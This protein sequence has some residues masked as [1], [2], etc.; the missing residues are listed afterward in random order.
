MGNEPGKSS[1]NKNNHTLRQE[2]SGLDLAKCESCLPKGQA[3][4]QLFFL[5]LLTC[6]L[7]TTSTLH[8]IM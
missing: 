1:S 8:H 6:K 7:A 5:A 2:R 4:I 3:V